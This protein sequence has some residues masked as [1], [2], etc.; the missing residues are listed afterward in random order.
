[1]CS[2]GF[3]ILPSFSKHKM[4]KKYIYFPHQQTQHRFLT[5]SMKSKKPHGLLCWRP[6]S[7]SREKEYLI[8]KISFEIQKNI[9][10]YLRVFSVHFYNVQRVWVFVKLQLPFICVKLCGISGP[11]NVI[12]CQDELLWVGERVVGVLQA[13]PLEMQQIS[14]VFS[15]WGTGRAGDVLCIGRLM[16]TRVSSLPPPRAPRYRIGIGTWKPTTISWKR[17][18]PHYNL[19]E[20]DI[21]GPAE[22]CGS[23]FFVRKAFAHNAELPQR[24]ERC[25]SRRA[26]ERSAKM[27]KRSSDVWRWHEPGDN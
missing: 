5:R 15:W 23:P 27:Q 12:G 25:A 1:M 19:K 14:P 10:I 8:Q 22:T 17:C 16:R 21:I 2:L 6:T 4:H 24:L 26:S 7:S 13:P 20:N 18:L 11:R 3:H 9:F